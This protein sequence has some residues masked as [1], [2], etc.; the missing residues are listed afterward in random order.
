M[1]DYRLGRILFIFALLITGWAFTLNATAELF[2]NE[3]FFD[4]GG[5]GQDNRDEY[6]ELRGTPSMSLADHYLIF[7]EHE[8]NE[9]HTGGAGRLESIFDL[10]AFSLGSNGFLLL[11]QDGNIYDDNSVAPGTTSIEHD[12]M[13]PAI[14][15]GWGDNNSSP[16]SSLVGHSGITN[17][18][19][20]GIVLE[21]GGATAMLI[22]SDGMLEPTLFS[23]PGVAFDMDKNN[24][25]L[26]G[27]QND[28][29]N[30]RDHW[31]I[32][33]SIGHFENDEIEFGR[34]YGRVNFAPDVIGQPIVPEDP[35]SPVLTPEFLATRLEP[36]A[37]YVG[38]G[39]EIEALARWGNSTGSTSADWHVF[40]LTDNPGSGSAGINPNGAPPVIDYRLS[41]SDS[42]DASCHPSDD[43]NAATPAPQPGVPPFAIE[44]SKGVP[45]GTKLT[46]TLGAPNY[47]TGD[48]NGDGY[49]DAGDYIV[50]RAMAGQTGF[51][52]SNHPAADANHD[53]VIDAVD[54]NA[55]LAHF[56]T[57]QIGGSGSG[58][59]VNNTS[60]VPEPAAVLLALFAIASRLQPRRRN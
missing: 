33:D 39:F 43:G 47:M 54:Y 2:I 12:N 3:I 1:H 19:T 9:A 51:T 15:E 35:L 56:G 59:H 26:D 18:G 20:R 25:G 21:N 16:G 57:P 36:G 45:Y 24:N 50:W 48:Y 14:T 7:I 44:S 42:S 41:C 40:N 53:F 27:T 28:T 32:L 22:R 4:P 52:E 37:E 6:I 17:A 60:A 55:W 29:L 34:M 31:A 49:V 13:N 10:G 23:S 38:L 46:T 30:W 8:D 5:A 11:R 58:G